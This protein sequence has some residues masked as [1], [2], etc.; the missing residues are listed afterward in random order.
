L[1]LPPGWVLT[2]PSEAEWEKAARGG[3]VVPGKGR[4]LSVHELAAAAASRFEAAGTP[5][6]FPGREFAWGDGFDSERANAESAMGQTSAVGGF[7]AGA[8]PYGCEEMSGNVWEWTRSLWGEG[9]GKP[10]YSYPYDAGDGAREDLNASDDVRR[11][12]RGGSYFSPAVN[13][14]CACRAWN[15]PDGRDDDLGFRVMLRPGPLSGSTP[16]P[17]AARHESR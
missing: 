12:V 13:A 16:E 17:G 14:R 11:V 2:L 8:S 15:R 7:A 6:R 1:Q 10:S 4:S 9:P 5:N 3:E